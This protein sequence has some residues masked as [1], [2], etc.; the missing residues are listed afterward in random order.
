MAVGAWV[1]YSWER[2]GGPSSRMR[3][4]V[5]SG[6]KNG[7]RRIEIEVVKE[8]GFARFGYDL[9]ADGSKARQVAQ[10]GPK[11]VVLLISD[12][13]EEKAKADPPPATPQGK[14]GK[15]A[16]PQ[17]RNVKVPAGKFRCKIVRTARGES[18]ID[19]GLMP[20]NIVRFDGKKEGTM[21]LLGRGF[22]ARPRILGKPRPFPKLGAMPT[23]VPHSLPFSP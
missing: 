13:P 22:D 20:M 6:D 1:E 12:E 11:G 17:W 19:P 18:C 9:L 3:F 21:I 4:A 23:I 8:G 15:P 5:V 7:R 2:P 14:K 10:L 16:P